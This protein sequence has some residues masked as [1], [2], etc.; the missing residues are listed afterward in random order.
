M[1]KL[2]RPII[3]ISF[4]SETYPFFQWDGKCSACRVYVSGP[5]TAIHWWKH[6][7]RCWRVEGHCSHCDEKVSLEEWE[8]HALGH[9]D[10]FA[11]RK[12]PIVSVTS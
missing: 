9:K 2:D 4:E 8:G 6:Q 11:P 1:Y 5:N 3:E 7:I 12:K 10:E